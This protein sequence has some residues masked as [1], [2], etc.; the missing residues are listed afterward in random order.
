MK[1]EKNVRMLAAKNWKISTDHGANKV[2]KVSSRV[3][4]E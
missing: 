2:N 4:V 1:S 3:Y